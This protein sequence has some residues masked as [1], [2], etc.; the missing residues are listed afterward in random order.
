MLGNRHPRGTSAEWA[1][2]LLLASLS[3]QHTNL[4][5]SRSEVGSLSGSINSASSLT[6]D[7]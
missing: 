6:V 5:K 2:F 4:M 7:S 3:G 1:K